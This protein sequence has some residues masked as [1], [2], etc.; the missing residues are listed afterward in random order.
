MIGSKY[1]FRSWKGLLIV[2]SFGNIFL[3]ATAIYLKASGQFDPLWSGS[4]IYLPI[5]FTYFLW[6]SPSPLI[7]IEHRSS[8]NQHRGNI[9][10]TALIQSLIPVRSNTSMFHSNSRA[11]F[12]RVLPVVYSVTLASCG[13]I[14]RQYLYSLFRTW[15]FIISRILIPF[16]SK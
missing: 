14:C 7:P 4:S 9:S 13:N 11:T 2:F 5:D 10:R 16:P 3:I 1:L 12:S 15:K 8:L 6:Y